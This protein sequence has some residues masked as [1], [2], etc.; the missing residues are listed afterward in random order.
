MRGGEVT[1]TG[2][3]ALHSFVRGHLSLTSN[4]LPIA[5]RKL[6]DETRYKTGSNQRQLVRRQLVRCSWMITM[7][8][9]TMTTWTF[10]MSD[11]H[12]L[13]TF[14]IKRV[15]F[16]F[17]ALILRI[18]QAP[19]PPPPYPPPGVTLWS[20]T[21]KI[22]HRWCHFFLLQYMADFYHGASGTHVVEAVVQEVSV[23]AP[24]HVQNP[25]MAVSLVSEQV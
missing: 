3:K 14:W 7:I 8:S 18:N 24:D 17:I 5:F 25:V 10:P 16:N 2:E 15:S 1:Q 12:S 9:M 11:S 22:N 20:L 4:G 13:S 19:L 21:F 6:R 23:F